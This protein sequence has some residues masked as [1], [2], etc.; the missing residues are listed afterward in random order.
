MVVA[1][2][3]K[4]MVEYNCAIGVIKFE[5]FWIKQPQINLQIYSY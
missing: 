1:K 5:P 4:Q 2:S 3:E